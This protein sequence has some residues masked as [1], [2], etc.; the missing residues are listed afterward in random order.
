MRSRDRLYLSPISL[1][2]S[3][4]SSSS[5]KRQRMIRDSMGIGIYKRSDGKMFFTQVFADF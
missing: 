1:S 5:P 3:S 2:V 4:S